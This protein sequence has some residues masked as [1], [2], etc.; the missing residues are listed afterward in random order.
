M[1][2]GQAQE[3][4]RCELAAANRVTEAR[5]SPDAVDR[6]SIATREGL[7]GSAMFRQERSTRSR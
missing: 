1:A 5:K 7:T 3:H 4:R 6:G 2:E